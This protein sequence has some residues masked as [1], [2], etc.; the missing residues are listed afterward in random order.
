MK[1]V[2]FLSVC[3]QVFFSSI[4]FASSQSEKI[5]AEVERKMDTVPLPDGCSIFGTPIIDTVKFDTE[6][7][8]TKGGKAHAIAISLMY[9]LKNPLKSSSLLWGDEYYSV[10][11]IMNLYMSLVKT[12]YDLTSDTVVFFEGLFQYGEICGVQIPGLDIR[13]PASKA[14]SD[15]FKVLGKWRVHGGASKADALEAIRIERERLD[16]IA[17][18]EEAKRRVEEYTRI[19]V[20]KKTQETTS[21]LRHR[22]AHGAYTLEDDDRATVKDPLLS[23]HPRSHY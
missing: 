10:E 22:K 19:E 20:A 16:A 23:K 2:I 18:E 15:L 9:I 1:N 11:E 21:T 12:L 17:V 8:G 13:I 5:L 7:L 3:F 6:H 14:R 4:C